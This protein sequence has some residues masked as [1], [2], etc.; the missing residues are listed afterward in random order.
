MSVVADAPARLEDLCAMARELGTLLD[1]A[2]IPTDGRAAWVADLEDRVYALSSGLPEG[3]EDFDAR[4]LWEMLHALRR[5]ADS[6]SD[7]EIELAAM[8]L[9][10]VARRL[11]RRLLHDELD[12]PRAA[13]DYV[14]RTLASVPAT[15]LARLLGVSV[16]TVGAWRAG[17]PVTRNT[18]RVVLV[19]H[20]I[21]YL[22][23]SLTAAGLLQWFAAP[24]HQLDDRTPLDLLDG[25]LAP[26]REALISLARGARGQL[27]D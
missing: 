15:D 16:K 2:R 12:E 7:D 5:A 8:M 11:G 25:D 23:S 3:T 10:D 24:R 14:L 26:A 1:T 19:A 13:A 22:R 18:E 4:R 6:G 17:R 27:A 20:V 21:T 9:G